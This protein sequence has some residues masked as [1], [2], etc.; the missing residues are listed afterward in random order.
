M[1][2]G[3]GG[4]GSGPQNPLAV[5]MDESKVI[6]ANFTK[7]PYLNVLNCLGESSGGAFRFKL[8]GILGEQYGIEASIN[9]KDWIR[10]ARLTNALGIVQFEDALG[11]NINHRFY[12]AAFLDTP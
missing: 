6:T 4:S 7:R 2:I 1:F 5:S 10:L 12:R 11:T 8:T 9:L 3:W